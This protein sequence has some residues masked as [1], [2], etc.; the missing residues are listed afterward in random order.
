MSLFHLQLEE[1]GKKP[2]DVNNLSLN[3]G[4]YSEKNEGLD[5]Y[6]LEHKKSR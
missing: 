6:V 1:S 2:F 5:R 4:L 3:T